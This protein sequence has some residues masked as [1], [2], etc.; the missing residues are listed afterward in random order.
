MA[1][2][3]VVDG[4]HYLVD[5]ELGMPRQAIEADPRGA[6][7]DCPDGSTLTRIPHP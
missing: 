1:S 4:L 5:F 2:A 7:I 6:W 3:V